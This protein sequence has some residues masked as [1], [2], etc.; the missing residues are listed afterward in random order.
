MQFLGRGTGGEVELPAGTYYVRVVSTNTL[1]NFDASDF[2]SYSFSVKPVSRVDRIKI[3]E[4]VSANGVKVEY[5]NGLLHRMDS[6]NGNVVAIK[7]TAYYV[8]GGVE[9]PA[10]TV[11][12]EGNVNLT[13][14]DRFYYLKNSV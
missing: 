6:A 5:D 3:T 4:I 12:P 14:M 10:V 8:V 9:Y 13:A 1:N 11:W 2:G 7:G